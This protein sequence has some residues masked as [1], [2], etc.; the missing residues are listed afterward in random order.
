MVAHLNQ[1]DFVLS[2]EIVS[3]AIAQ[4]AENRS[5]NSVLKE[6]LTSEGG[7]LDLS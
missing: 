6:I 2:N 5:M 7:A 3:A 1:S 4:I